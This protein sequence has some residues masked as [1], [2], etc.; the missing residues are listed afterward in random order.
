MATLEER[1]RIERWRNEVATLSNGVAELHVRGGAE[2]APVAVQ[3]APTTYTPISEPRLVPTL[4]KNNS[5]PPTGRPAK[6]VTLRRSPPHGIT[7]ATRNSEPHIIRVIEHPSSSEDSLDR[8]RRRRSSRTEK[9]YPAVTAATTRSRPTA[10]YATSR[11]GSERRSRRSPPLTRARSI[12]SRRSPSPLKYGIIRR[13]LK[14][15]ERESRRAHYDDSYDE[16]ERPRRPMKPPRPRATSVDG[17][18][19]YYPPPA[20]RDDRQSMRDHED[21]P[22]YYERRG[23]DRHYLGR[24]GTVRSSYGNRRRDDWDDDRRAAPDRFNQLHDE[25]DKTRSIGVRRLPPTD[26]DRR[27]RRR[28]FYDYD[29]Y[30]SRRS[31]R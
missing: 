3:T 19:A 26:D 21:S 8:H 14:L 2:P 16:Y 31:V 12:R 4:Q 11:D 20:P 23:P 1:R 15:P 29:D 18:R 6:H 27:P 25:A 28:S 5:Y 13:V 17:R 7:T 24:S 22:Y 30:G 9:S 10:N